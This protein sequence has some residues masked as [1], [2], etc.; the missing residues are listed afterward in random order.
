[1]TTIRLQTGIWPTLRYIVRACVA[2]V[3]V[4]TLVM[5]HI[6]Y[7]IGVTKKR[8]SEQRPLLHYEFGYGRTAN[9]PEKDRS[10]LEERI[11]Y[12]RIYNK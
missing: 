9:R 5:E 6:Q 10:K 8:Y 7:V 3:C 1:M 12:S 2:C 4:Y 11:S